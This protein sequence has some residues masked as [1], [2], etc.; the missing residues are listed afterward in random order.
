MEYTVEQLK[1][2]PTLEIAGTT[3]YVLCVVSNNLICVSEFGS[4][5]NPSAKMFELKTFY[6]KKENPD[7]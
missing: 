6:V 1:R 2:F 5:C 3:F 4:T 7:A